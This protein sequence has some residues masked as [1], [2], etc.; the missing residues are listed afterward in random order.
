MS[1]FHEA[2]LFHPDAFARA[3][4]PRVE[5]LQT[6]GSGYNLLRVE[7]IR[8]YEVSPQVRTLA[9]EH[10]GWGK[11]GIA[12]AFPERE[13]FGIADAAFWVTLLLYGHLAQLSDRRLG[14]NGYWETLDSVLMGFGWSDVRRR[15]LIEGRDFGDLARAW[16]NAGA[17]SYEGGEAAPTL[18]D[19][20]SWGFQSGRVGWLSDDGAGDPS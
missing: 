16:T 8:L 17:L 12:T 1:L 14:L 15:L 4:M 11:E 19:H 3:V 7:A 20:L 10:G 18:W 6:T 5:A 13:P 9:D 2:Y